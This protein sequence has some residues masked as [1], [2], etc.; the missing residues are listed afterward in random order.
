MRS[1]IPPEKGAQS[2]WSTRLSGGVDVEWTVRV[3]AYTPT[4]SLWVA[5][6][7]RC[8]CFG[9]PHTAPGDQV[10]RVDEFIAARNGADVKSRWVGANISA[11]MGRA[12]AAKAM[13]TPE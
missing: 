6:R 13:P 2:R 12:N 11:S 7:Y 1:Q 4:R 9:R 10:R 8:V 3:R 5:R